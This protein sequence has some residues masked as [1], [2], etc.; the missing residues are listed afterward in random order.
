MSWM[1]F[2]LQNRPF[3]FLLAQNVI[4]FIHENVHHSFCCPKQT[5]EV[6]CQVYDRV[7]LWSHEERRAIVSE[8]VLYTHMLEPPLYSPVLQQALC[9]GSSLSPFPKR[10]QKRHNRYRSLGFAAATQEISSGH[11][12]SRCC[13]KVH[14]RRLS[15]V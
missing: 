14:L 7:P 2:L 3:T 12:Q 15:G 8:N 5:R 6:V 4:L 9:I 13:Q 1:P 10:C 11:D